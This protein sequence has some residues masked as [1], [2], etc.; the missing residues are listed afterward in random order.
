[1]RVIIHLDC[2]WI[3]KC[4]LQ[5]HTFAVYS[6]GYRIIFGGR[7]ADAR[8][9]MGLVYGMHFEVCGLIF[10]SGYSGHFSFRFDL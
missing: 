4:C 5:F 8:W 9:L 3:R 6:I 1:M 2:W 7:F 10:P